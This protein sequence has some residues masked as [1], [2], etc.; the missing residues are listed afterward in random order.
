MP[1]D[2]LRDHISHLTRYALI[3][4]HNRAEA[5]DM[6]QDCL[7]HML[8]RAADQ[9]PVRDM[10]SYLLTAARNLYI[11]RCRQRQRKPT[12]IPLA[13]AIEQLGYQPRY[14]DRLM[15]RDIASGVAQLPVGQRAA[16]LLVALEELSYRQAASRLH[17]PVGTI[18]SRVHRAR[19]AL[20]PLR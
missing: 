19:A 14:D 15:L 17:V 12:A 1:D 18:Q 3:L 8:A 11:A 7:L 10:R 9:E 6:V 5:D 2:E 16:I 20:A 4:L 13:D